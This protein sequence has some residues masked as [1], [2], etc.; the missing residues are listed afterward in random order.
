MMV[1]IILYSTVFATVGKPSVIYL[2]LQP[3]MDMYYISVN[4]LDSFCLC[5]MSV[6]YDAPF[7]YSFPL[8]GQTM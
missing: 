8:F 5:F 3:C 1:D 6:F 2:F 4:P 7:C